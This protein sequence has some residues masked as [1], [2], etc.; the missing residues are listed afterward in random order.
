MILVFFVRLVLLT[1]TCLAAVSQGCIL[2]CVC[3]FFMVG[4]P[5]FSRSGGWVLC[6]GR[7][8]IV[9]NTVVV[10]VNSIF[11]CELGFVVLCVVFLVNQ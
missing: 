9:R 6:F 11:V 7:N 10:G 2:W 4:L 1:C 8:L 3:S 5:G